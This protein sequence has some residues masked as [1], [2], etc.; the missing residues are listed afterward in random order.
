MSDD[1]KNKDHD[2]VGDTIL[3][4]QVLQSGVDLPGQTRIGELQETPLP[5]RH[6]VT[7]SAYLSAELFNPDQAPL[8]KAYQEAL[9]KA[10]KGDVFALSTGKVI[11][12]DVGIQTDLKSDVTKTYAEFE[13]SE[14]QAQESRDHDLNVTDAQTSGLMD[15]EILRA[16]LLIAGTIIL[17]L[18]GVNVLGD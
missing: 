3:P 5:L 13:Y 8:I 18:L 16:L 6:T 4:K 2:K 15:N 17:T 12:Q 1:D 9:K 7:S 10:D 11:P 14:Q